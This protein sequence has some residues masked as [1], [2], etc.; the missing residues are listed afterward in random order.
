M[1]RLYWGDSPDFSQAKGYIELI[2]VQKIEDGCK[3]AKK[4][5]RAFTIVTRDRKL[6]LEAKDEDTK[7]LWVECLTFLVEQLKVSNELY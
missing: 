3:G 5:A 1:D 4:S 7:K 6:E 2:L